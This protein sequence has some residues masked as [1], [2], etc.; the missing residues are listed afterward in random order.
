[1]GKDALSLAAW[2]ATCFNSCLNPLSFA[3]M[4]CAQQP[5]AVPDRPFFSS[6]SV[7]HWCVLPQVRF[8]ELRFNSAHFSDDLFALSQLPAPSHL[9]RSVSKRRAHWLASRYAVRHAMATCGIDDVVLGNHADRSPRWPTGIS[10]SLSHTE[11]R[12][13]VVYSEEPRLL[14]IDVEQKMSLSTAEEVADTLVSASELSLLRY[15]RLDFASALTLT[16]SLKESLYKAVWPRCQQLMDF[17]QAEVIE[18]DSRRGVAR[19]RLCESL[20]PF[21]GGRTFIAAFQI[22]EAEITTLVAAPV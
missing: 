11:G 10:A 17:H 16:F 9:N 19:L 7:S 3:P 6:M 14:G 2:H 18:L 8:C 15:C 1:M 5:V 12:A 22:Q 4:F 20:T 13:L 21:V